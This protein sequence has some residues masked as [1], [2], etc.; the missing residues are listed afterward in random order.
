M[1]DFKTT[2]DL[3]QVQD[4]RWM[5]VCQKSSQQDIYDIM[6]EDEMVKIG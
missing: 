2:Y 1:H 5:N 4:I 3:K 6:N